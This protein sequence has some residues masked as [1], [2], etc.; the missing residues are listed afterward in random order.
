MEELLTAEEVAKILKVSP[1]AVFKWAKKRI[2]PSYR[3]YEKCLRFKKPDIEAF[4]E[5]GK[6][7]ELRY[8]RS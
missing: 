3:I 6:G 2:I 4:I 1:S 7:V 5:K 8:D